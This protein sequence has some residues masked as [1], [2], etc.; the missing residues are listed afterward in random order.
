MTIYAYVT[1]TFCF[2]NGFYTEKVYKDLTKLWSWTGPITRRYISL[3]NRPFQSHCVKKTRSATL[4][5]IEQRDGARL[6]L[7]ITFIIVNEVGRWHVEI[8]GCVDFLE[9]VRSGSATDT[10]RRTDVDSIVITFYLRCHRRRVI[11]LNTHRDRMLRYPTFCW[12][13]TPHLS[14]ILTCP[15]STMIGCWM[16]AESNWSSPPPTAILHAEWQEI[17]VGRPILWYVSRILVY[18]LEKYV[19]RKRRNLLISGSVA[20]TERFAPKIAS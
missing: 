8:A 9:A 6:M 20:W 11:P 4:R 1:V 18:C 16:A 14:P 19:W 15:V 13:R 2:G 12:V 7:S 10:C 17:Y 3:S 5:S